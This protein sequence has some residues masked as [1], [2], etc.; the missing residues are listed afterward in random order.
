MTY[1]MTAADAANGTIQLPPGWIAVD[2]MFDPLGDSGQQTIDNFDNLNYRLAN[3]DFFNFSW[4]V[5][6]DMVT[7][8]H[9]FQEK[10]NLIKLYFTPDTRFRYN[11]V[12]GIVTLYNNFLYPQKIYVIHGY[13][14]LD[15]KNVPQ[16]Y[17][18]PWLKKY[19]IALIGLQWGSNISKYD[20]VQL[21]GSITLNGKD[22]YERYA[23]L[24]KDLEEEF[25]S[26]YEAPPTFF[27]E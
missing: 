10:I 3:S 2:E 27:M 22:I 4:T 14:A 26:E 12:S 24:K 16:M 1:T 15:P 6:S 7:S 9:L 13:R 8:Y 25:R 5:A 23:T 17:N 19:T 21:P 20:G 11:A 18:D